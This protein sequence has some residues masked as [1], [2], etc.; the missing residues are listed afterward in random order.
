MKYKDLLLEAIEELL[1]KVAIDMENYKGGPMGKAR[2]QLDKKQ[3]MLEKL[4]HE[5]YVQI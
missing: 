1:Y 5:I 3:K 2:K 4:Q